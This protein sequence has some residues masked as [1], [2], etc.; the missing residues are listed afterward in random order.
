MNESSLIPLKILVERAVRPVRA[1]PRRKR[2]MRE[3]LLAHVLAVFEEESVRTG[4]EGTALE[5]TRLRFGNPTE[6][7]GELQQSVPWLDLIAWF[8]ANPALVHPG[9]SARRRAVRHAVSMGLQFVTLDLILFVLL[10]LFLGLCTWGIGLPEGA[11]LHLAGMAALS[12]PFFF[13]VV[14]GLVLLG[15]GMFHALDGTAGRS[16]PGMLLVTLVSG[17]VGPAVMFVGLLASIDHSGDI[18]TR[19]SD[20][21][22]MLPGLVAAVPYALLF[23]AYRIRQVLSGLLV[24][25]WWRTLLVDAGWL[26]AVSGGAVGLG[27]AISGNLS[28]S[29]E[30]NLPPILV[31]MQWLI[32]ADVI[33]S[34]PG[35]L[36]RIQSDREW[37]S[38]PIDGETGAAA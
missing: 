18:R 12:L 8:L 20:E 16:W 13:L 9:E 11:L 5:R 14:A 4:V 17:L 21:L 28:I 19:L 36:A 27:L 10:F 31:L 15:H 37:A 2:K 32:L 30:K 6:L 1:G 24:R 26:L 33:L 35:P 38:L 7:T 29:V 3:E 22:V 34:L 25:S 23:L